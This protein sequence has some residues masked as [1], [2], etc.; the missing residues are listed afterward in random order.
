MKTVSRPFKLTLL[1]FFLFYSSIFFTAKAQYTSS[2]Q[3]VWWNVENLFDCEHDSLKND[4]EFLPQSIRHWT[5]YRLNKKLHQITQSVVEIGKWNP[6]VLIGLCEVENDNV[7]THLTKYSALKNLQYSYVMTH[8]DDLRGIDVALLYLRDQFKLISQEEVVIPSYNHKPTRNILHVTGILL[9]LDTLDV[10]LCHLPSQIGGK[11]STIH[12]SMVTAILKEQIDAVMTQRNHPNLLVMGD[13]NS[14]LSSPI[15]TKILGINNPNDTPIKENQIYHLFYD[16]AKQKG[17]GSYKYKGFW[18]LID[19]ILIS[20]RLLN[21]QSALHTSATKAK[22]IELPSLLEE[23]LKYGGQKPYR[24][25]YGMK[26]Q[27]GVSDHLPLY[28]EFE[29]NW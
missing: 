12:R 9:S 26:Y 24:T 16:V 29:L 11:T 19:H 25:Y 18:Q 1:F 15:F 3:V 7:L 14:D 8:S 5:S 17:V 27:A 13:F 23:D 28:V 21:P 4:Y 20:G 2:F 22:I 6:P 10:F